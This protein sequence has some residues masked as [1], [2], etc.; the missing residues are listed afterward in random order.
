[1]AQDRARQIGGRFND[2]TNYDTWMRMGIWTENL[3]LPAVLNEC[4]LQSYSGTI[5]LFPNT[6]HLGPAR[7]KNLRAVGAFLVS[8]EWDGQ[9]VARVTVFSEKGRPVRLASPWGKAEVRVYRSR[10]NRPAV[11][12]QEGSVV[13]FETE[14]GEEY[15]VG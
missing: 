8:A 12:E 1:V 3:A 9:V 7:F 14:A 6:L 10:G 4:L 2:A 13:T 11:V 15:R 5:R